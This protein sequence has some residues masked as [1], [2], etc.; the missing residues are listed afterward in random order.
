M[1]TATPEAS[2]AWRLINVSKRLGGRAALVDVSIS[3]GAFDEPQRIEVL[4]Q[5]GLEGK[6]PSLMDLDAVEEV[7]TTEQNDGAEALARI[8]ASNHQ[9]PDHDTE[10]WH[11][12][13]SRPK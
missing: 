7:G 9:H 11:P 1:S 6:H 10:Q 13:T 8:R 3:I 12:R 2:P 5:M 4:Y